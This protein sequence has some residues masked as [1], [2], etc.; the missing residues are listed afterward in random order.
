MQ[1]KSSQRLRTAAKGVLRRLGYELRHCPQLVPSGTDLARDLRLV[2]TKG[3]PVCFD[4]GANCGQTIETL[5]NIFEAPRIF[6]FEPSTEMFS[7]LKSKLST[8]VSLYNVALGDRPST[9]EF[10]NYNDP[11]LSSFLA[12]ADDP[13]NEFRGVRAKSKQIVQVQTVDAFMVKER[14]DSIDLLKI[15]TQGYDLK[16]LAGAENSLKQGAIGAVL[17]ELNFVKLY[18]EQGNPFEIIR[19]LAAH[20]VRL[21]DYYDK[22]RNGLI[23]ASCNALFMKI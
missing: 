5:Q 1:P 14:L 7:F 21:V 4:V 2:V 22:V 23:L 15:D 13:E 6:A 12:L 18:V 10:T 17:V 16:V 8:R 9:Q 19:F 3:E 20:N 11:C